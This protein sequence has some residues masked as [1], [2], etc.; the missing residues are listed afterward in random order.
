M[1]KFSISIFS[2]LYL[3]TY[4]LV[5]R[6]GLCLFSSISPRL[7]T[8]LNRC[9]I[10][11]NLLGW[12]PESKK[13][14]KLSVHEHLSPRKE[15][16]NPSYLPCLICICVCEVSFNYKEFDAGKW[17]HSL[18]GSGDTEVSKTNLVASFTE[19]IIWN[20]REIPTITHTQNPATM[21]SESL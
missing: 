1:I 6:Y 4:I 16:R 12:T 14:N 5:G 20:K 15:V 7:N 3:S 9:L 10:N 17:V 8:L 21:L 11:I 18:I 2:D 13:T 19:L